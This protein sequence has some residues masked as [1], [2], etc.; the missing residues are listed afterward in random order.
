MFYREVRQPSPMKKRHRVRQDQESLGAFRCHRVE[1]A[2]EGIGTTHLQSLKL[3]PQRST[4]QPEGPFTVSRMPWIV[5][6]PQERDPRRSRNRLLEELELLNA[7]VHGQG[8]CAGD[9]SAR[10]REAGNEAQLNRIRECS[11]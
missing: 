3:K 2:V 4:T 7:Q 11:S 9:V 1:R 5:G 8:R 10:S 6:I